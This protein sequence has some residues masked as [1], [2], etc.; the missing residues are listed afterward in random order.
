MLSEFL[1]LLQGVEL[2]ARFCP[3]PA[4]QLSVADEARTTGP[5]SNTS[6]WIG[7]KVLNLS[8]NKLG[9]ACGRGLAALLSQC[10]G[11]HELCLTSCRLGPLSFDQDTGLGKALKG[12]NC[13]YNYYDEKGQE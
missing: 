1:I 5:S 7:L 11:L 4:P 9:V 8:F 10:K 12:V 6:P 2:L 13:L 3:A